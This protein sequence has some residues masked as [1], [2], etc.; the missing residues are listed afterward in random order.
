[1]KKAPRVGM[2]RSRKWTNGKGSLEVARKGGNE[3]SIVGVLREI[4]LVVAKEDCGETAG[5]VITSCK[6]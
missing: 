5:N 3:G 1:M 4:G 2:E 6:L